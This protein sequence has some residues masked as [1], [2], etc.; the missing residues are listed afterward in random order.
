MKKCWT[1]PPGVWGHRSH[2]Q[3]LTNGVFQEMY[4]VS[5]ICFIKM[6]LPHTHTHTCTHKHVHTQSNAGTHHSNPTTQHPLQ[7]VSLSSIQ[8]CKSHP[9][10]H[11]LLLSVPAQQPS[12]LETLCVATALGY[13]RGVQTLSLKGQIVNILGCTISIMIQLCPCRV[14]AVDNNVTEQTRLGFN[15]IIPNM[16]GGSAFGPLAILC[17]LLPYTKVD[18]YFWISVGHVHVC[19][20]DVSAEYFKVQWKRNILVAELKLN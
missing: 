11:H 10:A 6:E 2:T 9:L 8:L 18:F 16:G 1:W 7:K 4:I 12:F 20:V 17:Q 5:L 15:K 19:I 14:W 13:F 3:G